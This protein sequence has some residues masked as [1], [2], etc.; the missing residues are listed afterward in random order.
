MTSLILLSAALLSVGTYVDKMIIDEGISRSNYFY[1][2]CLTMIPFSMCSLGMELVNGFFHF[3]LNLSLIL[4]L[5]AA[6]ILRYC[7][8]N[9]FVSCYRELQPF[10]FESYMT[11]S[12]VFSFIFDVVLG[13]QNFHVMK[14]I[15]IILILVG[16][17][18]VN[19]LKFQLKG[20]GK[21][22]LIRIFCELVTGYI[23][24][25]ALRQCS[26]SLFILLLNLSLTL[27]FTPIYRS[28]KKEVR[29]GK[30]LFWLIM[31][32]QA[33]G[34]T[35]TYLNNHLSSKSVTLSQFVSPVSL[36]IIMVAAMFMKSKKRPSFL[37]GAGI[38]LASAGVI[39]MNMYF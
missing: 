1:Y 35:V 34:F 12:L 17:L 22:L 8:Q 13:V 7:R 16:I 37:N 33:F 14:L 19:S 11:L 29:I 26:N 4:L 15:S 9:S 28:W 39:L 31:L 36:L 3:E 24:F 6:A 25:A 5:I 38:V 32:Q 20:I 2:M 18:M 30:K 10:E 23:I 21:N 27:I